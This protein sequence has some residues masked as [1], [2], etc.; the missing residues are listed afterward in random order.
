MTCCAPNVVG[1][2]LV[3]LVALTVAVSA[4][5]SLVLAVVGWAQRRRGRSARAVP[6]TA[7]ASGGIALGLPLMLALVATIRGDPRVLELDLR[8]ARPVSLLG[9]DECPGFA[10]TYQLDSPRVDLEP[11]DG[12][13]IRTEVVNTVFGVERGHIQKLRFRGPARTVAWRRSEYGGGRAKSAPPQKVWIWS[14][15]KRVGTGS[16]APAHPTWWWSCRCGRS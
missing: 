16:T 13:A 4:L 6:K 8:G 11:P 1:G 15:D 2:L 10:G 5:V 3:V 14:P 7:V 9:K 12:R